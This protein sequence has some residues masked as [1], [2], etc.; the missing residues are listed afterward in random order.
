MK[1]R[2]VPLMVVMMLMVGMS[3]RADVLPYQDPTLSIE[4]RVADLLSRM[5]LEEKIGQ[6]TQVEVNS[7]TPEDVTRYFI[8]SIL[9]GGGGYPA[10]N[11]TVAGWADMVT[12]YQDAAL[13]TALAI[14]MIY[15]VD[16]VHGHSNLSGAV[17]FPHNIGLGAARNP[18]LVTQI[19]QIT[20]TEMIATGIYWN[21][22]P[23][24]AV[25]QDYRWGRTYEGYSEDTTLVTELAT[26]MLIGLQGE[27][28]SDTLSVLGTAKHFVGDGGTAFGTSPLDNALLDRGE[29]AV[30]EATLREIHLAPYPGVIANGARSIMVS[31]SSWNGIRMHGQEYLIQDVL[32]GELGFTGFIVSD[33]AGVDDVAPVYYDAVV[34]AINA[35]IDMNMVPYDYL[36]YIDTMKQ[37]VAN[38]DISLE[39]INEAVTNILRVKFELGLFDRP[40]PNADLQALV[41]SDEHRAVAREAVSQSLVLLKN[42]NGALPI[43]ANTEQIVFVAGTGADNLGMQAGGWSI[44]WQGFEGNDAT[45]GTTILAALQAGVGESV[46]VQYSR[47]GDFDGERGDVGIVVVGEQP[48]AEYE[49][50]DPDLLLDTRDVRLI[51]AMREQVDKLI[52]VQLSGRPLVIDTSLNLA[53]AWVAAWLPGTEGAGVTDVLFGEQDFVGK[54]SYTWLRNIE[55]LPFDFENMPTEGCAAPLFP[56]GYGLSYSDVSAAAA[57]LELALECAPAA[58][59]EVDPTT[60]SPDSTP[61]VALPSAESEAFGAEDVLAY[62]PGEV[63]YIPYPVSITLDGNLSDWNGIPFEVVTQGTMTSSDPAENGSVQFSLASDGENIYVY[64]VMPDAT[65]VTGEHGQDFWNEDSLEFYMNFSGDLARTSYGDGVFQVNINPGNLGNTDPNALVY[66]GVNA[67]EAGFSAF[68]FRTA[69]GWGFEAAVP[70]PDTVP[71]EQGSVIGFQ[72]HANGSSGGDRDV[73]LIWSNADT[74]DQSYL[75]PS[76][77]GIGMFYEVGNTEVPPV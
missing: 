28:L 30:D 7:I 61:V 11:N 71:V 16:A 33:W 57:W 49:G 41:G 38:G 58:V 9:S 60:V 48:Y 45:V 63:A 40:Y 39:R 34:L 31:Y 2:L 19:G 44:E 69:D 37:A 46:T 22:A 51:T 70:I 50:D 8:G 65:I 6:M 12:A 24:L 13:S 25:P 59:A 27:N 62:V 64:M 29:T 74:S 35:G 18:E 72:V 32:R 77:F 47:R 67:T 1:L 76:L 73:K 26:A 14:P 55:Q 23:V 53:D 52:V 10:G 21:F 68:V 17:L 54:L 75:N 3:V 20:A 36:R 4:E 56:Y 15:G 43:N 5:T 42:E 66:T